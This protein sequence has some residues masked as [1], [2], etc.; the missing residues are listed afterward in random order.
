[1]TLAKLDSLK[2]PA[3]IVAALA[4]AAGV[5]AG[6]EKPAVELAAEAPRATQAAVRSEALAADT[7]LDL[8]VLERRGAAAPQADLFARR[9]FAPARARQAPAAAPAPSAPP[10]PFRYIG[11]LIEDGK[12]EIILLRGSEHLT[13]AEPGAL[14]AE[15]RVDALSESSIAFTYLPLNTR[16]TLDIR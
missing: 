6:R 1:M 16:Q 5:V 14:D 4:L 2:R 12:L 10:L 3:L 15:Y 7:D 11:Q 9:S 13:V 8:S